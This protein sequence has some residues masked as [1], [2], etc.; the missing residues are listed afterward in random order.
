MVTIHSGEYIDQSH[1]VG[2]F[3]ERI[4]SFPPSYRLDEALPLEYLKDLSHIGIRNFL[5]SADFT[6]RAQLTRLD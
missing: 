2:R 4:T 3:S 5:V 6:G 1:L